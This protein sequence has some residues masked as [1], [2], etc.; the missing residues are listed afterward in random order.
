LRKY[1]KNPYEIDEE[2][3]KYDEALTS[4]DRVYSMAEEINS[5]VFGIQT[6]L[7]TSYK[8][9][10]EDE[11]EEQPQYKKM[12]GVHCYDILRNPSYVQ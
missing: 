5:R 1:F 6:M 7:E 4:S 10:A 8:D 3:P 11:P 9:L 2:I 12:I